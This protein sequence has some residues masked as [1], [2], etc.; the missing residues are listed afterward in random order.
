MTRL[1]HKDKPFVKFD[2]CIQSELTVHTFFYIAGNGMFFSHLF[3][4]SVHTVCIS[5]VHISIVSLETG[6]RSKFEKQRREIIFSSAS[7][8]I[9]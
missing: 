6:A 3:G 7:S 1:K 5:A 8:A 4:G 2:S 9:L